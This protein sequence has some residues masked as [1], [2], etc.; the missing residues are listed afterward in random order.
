M[1]ECSWFITT[2]SST[3]ERNIN[4][5]INQSSFYSTNI[6]G[7]ARLSGAT[8]KSLLNSKIDEAV[9]QHQKVLGHACVY[10]GK[11]RSKRYVL[12]HILKVGTAVDERTDSGKLFQR[13]GTQELNYLFPALVLTLGTDK[14]RYKIGHWLALFHAILIEWV[15]SIE[16]RQ[17]QT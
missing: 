2:F 15:S 9:P 1:C 11:V 17:G 3:L 14:V 5:S 10:G 12:R 16:G 13:E 8:S 7:I 4:Q 6:P